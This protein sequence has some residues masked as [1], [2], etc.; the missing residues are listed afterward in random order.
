MRHTTTGCNLDGDLQLV[1]IR[2]I[3]R[4]NVYA[5]SFGSITL[6]TNYH[7]ILVELVER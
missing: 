5:E 6:G 3:G 7:E 4:L 2:R 1:I